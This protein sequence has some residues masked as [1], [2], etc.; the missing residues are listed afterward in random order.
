MTFV[1]FDWELE[2]ADIGLL[3]G[4][5]VGIFVSCCVGLR[6]SDGGVRLKKIP[7]GNLC[8][9]E[10]STGETDEGPVSWIRVGISVGEK[11]TM[12]ESLTSTVGSNEIFTVGERDGLSVGSNEGL[13]DCLN[14]GTTVGSID[15]PSE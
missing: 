15:G 6:L 4:D 5:E 11:D 12:L 3:D 8:E 14:A 2:P 1:C 9:K 13:A 7:G 10:L